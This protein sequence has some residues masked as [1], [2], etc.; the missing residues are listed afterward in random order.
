MIRIGHKVCI[1]SEFRHPV[2]RLGLQLNG[3][4]FGYFLLPE[5]DAHTHRSSDKAR[6]VGI[7]GDVVL[8]QFLS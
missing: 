3:K 5:S 4:I 2:H 8:F 6:R 7:D 1:R